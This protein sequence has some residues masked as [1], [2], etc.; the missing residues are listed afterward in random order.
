M[1]LEFILCTGALL[2]IG[3][4]ASIAVKINNKIHDEEVKRKEAEREY[5]SKIW[6][7]DLKKKHPQIYK[8]I[9]ENKDKQK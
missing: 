8:L 3:Y 4:F 7:S 2:F 9:Q 6:M 1:F 5:E